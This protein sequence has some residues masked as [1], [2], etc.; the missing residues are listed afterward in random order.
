M[1]ITSFVVTSWKQFEKRVNLMTTNAAVNNI[2]TVSLRFQHRGAHKATAS[3]R[4]SSPPPSQI[5]VEETKYSIL[6]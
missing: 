6:T 2:K 4:D 3:P 1:V 5:K